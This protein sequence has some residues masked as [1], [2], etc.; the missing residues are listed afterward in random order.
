MV[1]HGQR[2]SPRIIEKMGNIVDAFTLA[3]IRTGS[4][5]GY[6]STSRSKSDLFDDKLEGRA[7][8]TLVHHG[9]TSSGSHLSPI[10]EQTN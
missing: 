8:G 6:T 10:V 1:M 9:G 7:Q 2:R 5:D 4:S 3:A